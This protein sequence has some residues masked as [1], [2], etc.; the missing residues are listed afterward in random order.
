LSTFG[1]TRDQANTPCCGETKGKMELSCLLIFLESTSGIAGVR[2]SFLKFLRFIS[3]LRARKLS[4]CF[5]LIFPKPICMTRCHLS[6][7][8]SPLTLLS[9]FT[10]HRTHF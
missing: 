10:C 1:P 7:K 3:E 2:N 5:C 8:V 4:Q 9:T 6:P